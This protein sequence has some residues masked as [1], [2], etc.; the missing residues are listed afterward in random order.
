LRLAEFEA[1]VED[2]KQVGVIDDEVTLRRW[3]DLS[4]GEKFDR[5]MDQ[6][7][8]L[9]LGSE[10][11][12]YGV[13]FR[14]VDM[15]RVP[16]ETRREFESNRQEA[17]ANRTDSDGSEFPMTREEQKKLFAE[18]ETDY[19]ARRAEDGNPGTRV[20]SSG[21]LA[22][23]HDGPERGNGRYQVWQDRGWPES[24]LA[25]M[26]HGEQTP[27][28]E[29]YI[30]VANVQ[31]ESLAQAMELTV[32]TGSFLRPDGDPPHKSWIQNEGVQV[33]VKRPYSRDTDVGDV[34]VDPQG[35]A[36]RVERDGFTEVQ[37]AH[38]SLPSPAAIADDRDGAP[39]AEGANLADKPAYA[40]RL[41]TTQ[42]IAGSTSNSSSISGLGF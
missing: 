36:Y 25:H 7:T 16:E 33:L 1:R 17:W 39:T 8:G 35:L 30:H 32:D 9:Y 15:T 5:I 14:E 37:A 11:S 34:I 12:A 38:Q 18:W 22:A 3:G 2:F 41:G 4:E 10:S 6:V 42:S 28:P 26:L 29:G 31:A 23:D 20:T 27:F 19:A 40:I 13:L 24:R 21:E